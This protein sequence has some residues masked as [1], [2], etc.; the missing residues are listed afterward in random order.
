MA[1]RLM[2]GSPRP[3]A[4]WSVTRTTGRLRPC[5]KHTNTPEA[6]VKAPAGRR[7]S[8]QDAPEIERRH[9]AN[10]RS[11]HLSAPA[12]MANRSERQTFDHCALPWA[13]HH[14]AAQAEHLGNPRWGGWLGGIWAPQA[15]GTVHGCVADGLCKSPAVG[16]AEEPWRLLAGA[17][18]GSG[19]VLCWAGSPPPLG[20]KG[21]WAVAFPV[22]EM[23]KRFR[24]PAVKARALWF[25]DW[26]RRAL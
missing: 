23:P 8:D 22:Q 26:V 3:R 5:P 21:S 12:Q 1:V 4:G 19:R 6:L 9:A 13:G 18:A 17:L 10:L 24:S 11:G 14:K 16:R 7:A 2:D 20:G 25:S 15:S